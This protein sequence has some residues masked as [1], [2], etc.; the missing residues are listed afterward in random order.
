VRRSGFTRRPAVDGWP[1]G[2]TAWIGR[3][4]VYSLAGTDYT[5]GLASLHKQYRQRPA[6]TAGRRVNP[7]LSAS[8]SFWGGVA[9]TLNNA[10]WRQNEPGPA[11]AETSHDL[12][13]GLTLVP[14]SSV[15]LIIRSWSCSPRHLERHAG[16]SAERLA[17]CASFSTTSSGLRR[18][19]R[20]PSLA[21]PRIAPA[22]A[23]ASPAPSEAGD[24]SSQPG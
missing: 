5:Y 11:R 24:V 9:H 10:S 7:D 14:R 17:L 12:T 8:K 20:L 6:S 1:L 22:W 16:N 19:T 3:G 4:L 15:A 18:N 2:G 21:W 23:A 13:A